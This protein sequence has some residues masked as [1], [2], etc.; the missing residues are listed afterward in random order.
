MET[1]LCGKRRC[2]LVFLGHLHGSCIMYEL[3]LKLQ[4]SHWKFAS[5][6]PLQISTSRLLCPCMSGETRFAQ[7]H[8]YHVSGVKFK[9][10][11]Q[12]ETHTIVLLCK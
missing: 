6:S 1:K 5:G 3:C 8:S 10:S 12:Q 2:F 7:T 11:L 9:L 4:S